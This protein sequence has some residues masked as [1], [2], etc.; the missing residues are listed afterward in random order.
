MKRVNLLSV[1]IRHWAPCQKE[2][3]NVGAGGNVGVGG[4]VGVDADVLSIL[5]WK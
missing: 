1:G 4:C 3:E 2:G 5:L